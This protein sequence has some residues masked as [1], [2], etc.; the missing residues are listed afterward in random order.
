[1]DLSLLFSWHGL[2]EEVLYGLPQLEVM[3]ME[4]QIRHS[5][6]LSCGETSK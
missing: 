2:P 6:S 1:M 3:G 4:N 5:N